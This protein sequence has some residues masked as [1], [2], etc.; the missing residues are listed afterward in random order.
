M[1]RKEYSRKFIFFTWR[2]EKEE[3]E[4]EA[5]HTKKPLFPRHPYFKVA[6]K[7]EE[8]R[9]PEYKPSKMEKLLEI[10]YEE[11]IPNFL[12]YV[13]IFSLVGVRALIWGYN[14]LVVSSLVP[15]LVSRRV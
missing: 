3:K 14:S 1:P 9:R 7:R 13:F 5:P 4:R 12:F 8:K 2:F 10:Q 15:L 11:I 6:P